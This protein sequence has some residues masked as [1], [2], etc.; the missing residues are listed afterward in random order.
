MV[1]TAAARAIRL[2]D[3][4][5]YLHNHPGI[6]LKEVAEEFGVTVPEIVKDLDLLFMCGLPDIRRWS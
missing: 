2:I 5:P 6:S 3:L 1:E 4:V